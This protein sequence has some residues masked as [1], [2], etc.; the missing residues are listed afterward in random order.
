M[1]FAEEFFSELCHINIAN[2]DGEL[3]TLVPF[4]GR[5]LTAE[6]VAD[7]DVLLVRSITQVNEELLHLNDKLIFV[8]SATI[9]TDHI[10]QAYLE[11]LDAKRN[12]QSK[13]ETDKDADSIIDMHNEG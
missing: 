13:E 6:Q 2:C 1:P 9:G 7:A 5:T 10:D 11:K 8:G 4:S 12:N 3:G